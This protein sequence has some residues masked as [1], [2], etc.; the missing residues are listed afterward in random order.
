MSDAALELAQLLL[1]AGLS[2]LTLTDEKHAN[3]PILLQL[4]DADETLLLVYSYVKS[5]ERRSTDGFGIATAD[6]RDVQRCRPG[7]SETELI[8]ECDGTSTKTLQCSDTAQRDTLIECILTL[9]S[10]LSGAAAA[11]AAA[12]ATAAAASARSSLA[13]RQSIGSRRHSVEVSYHHIRTTKLQEV[14]VSDAVY[15][16]V[17]TISNS[18]QQQQWR[19]ESKQR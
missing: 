10:E 8:V 1:G 17:V 2:G 14:A 6:V 15:A 16:L 12:A 9:Y 5:D 11:A 13:A 7:A 19:C 18:R 3:K 4:I